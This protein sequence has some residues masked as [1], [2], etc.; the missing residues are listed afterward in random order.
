VVEK[1]GDKLVTDLASGG[2]IWGRC[3]DPQFRSISRMPCTRKEFGRPD[4]DWP[5]RWPD[6]ADW[7]LRLFAFQVIRAAK[8]AFA[9]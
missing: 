1:V 2:R 4:S 3:L 7:L 6:R 8:N 5:E 9:I